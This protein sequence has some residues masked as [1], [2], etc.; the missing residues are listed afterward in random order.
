MEM[1]IEKQT[2]LYE[3]K[4]KKIWTTNQPDFLISEFKDSI[5]AFNERRERFRRERGI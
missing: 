5:T 1:D 2:L 3:G 4:A